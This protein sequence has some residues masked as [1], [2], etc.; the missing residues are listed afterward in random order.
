MGFGADTVEKHNKDKK[1]KSKFAKVLRTILLSGLLVA[2]GSVITLKVVDNPKLLETLHNSTKTASE[3]V[4]GKTTTTNT[5]SR[6]TA[7]RPV[8]LVK[9]TDSQKASA[10]EEY[11]TDIRG[12]AEEEKR[13]VENPTLEGLQGEMRELIA[14]YDSG[15]TDKVLPLIG[16]IAEQ[17]DFGTPHERY[18]KAHNLGS[19]NKPTDRGVYL[20]ALAAQ[21]A[22]IV[23]LNTAIN[24]RTEVRLGQEFNANAQRDLL[25]LNN[26]YA[27]KEERVEEITSSNSYNKDKVLKAVT[28]RDA[29]FGK[30]QAKATEMNLM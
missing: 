24:K 30:I 29:A 1:K 28:E 15:N 16:L 18:I 11:I 20:Q 2:T 19:K 27:D 7:P 5:A 25:N 17:S 21:R 26:Q 23:T 6:T 3:L 13:F 8:E 22:E 12:I 14:Y 9:L 10:Y 4:S